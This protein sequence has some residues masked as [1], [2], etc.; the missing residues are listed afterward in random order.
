MAA[1]SD[2]LSLA[3]LSN[4]S[5]S[6]P[7]ALQR[8]NTKA[9]GQGDERQACSFAHPYPVPTTS[10]ETRALPTANTETT[11]EEERAEVSSFIVPR[12][13]SVFYTQINRRR[14]LALRTI[15]VPPSLFSS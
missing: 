13:L 3:P 9:G 11:G 7:N 14:S 2:D 1:D 4:A 12:S 6:Y 8:E 5:V 15:K 10:T